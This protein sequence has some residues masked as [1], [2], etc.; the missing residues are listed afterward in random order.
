MKINNLCV[1]GHTSD[2]AIVAACTTVKTFVEGKWVTAQA[3]PEDELGYQQSVVD[4][5]L[6]RQAKAYRDTLRKQDAQENRPQAVL[7]KAA[8]VATDVNAGHHLRASLLSVASKATVKALETVLAGFEKAEKAAAFKQ[9]MAA[10]KKAK[11]VAKKVEAYFD[12]VSP[13]YAGKSC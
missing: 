13:I 6:V 8:L 1:H 3:V 10:G 9:R 4:H 2:A 5:M 7:A 12:K 11:A